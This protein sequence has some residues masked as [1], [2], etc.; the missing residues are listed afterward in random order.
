MG[1]AV[2]QGQGSYGIAP[3]SHAAPQYSA[4]PPVP[5]SQYS[6]PPPAKPFSAPP[7]Q[8]QGYS[9]CSISSPGGAAQYGAT[10]SPY[11][12]SYGTPSSN[13]VRPLLSTDLTLNVGAARAGVCF[14]RVQLDTSVEQRGSWLRGRNVLGELAQCSHTVAGALLIC[15]QE[16]LAGMQVNDVTGEGVPGAR[17]SALWNAPTQSCD[18]QSEK[19]E[20]RRG[21]GEC[22][23]ISHLKPAV[24]CRATRPCRSRSRPCPAAT[25]A[26]PPLPAS[27]RAA[28]PPTS[29]RPP[30][31]AAPTT[32]PTARL[33]AARHRH[34]ASLGTSLWKRYILTTSLT[35]V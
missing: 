26:V 2:L 32:A 33:A 21:G 13:S 19:M 22:V 24:M 35:I 15:S 5:V 18:G 6:A 11:A 25:P 31:A 10:S 12:G 34:P 16:H 27:T 8:A 29:R 9:N 23:S 30:R 3:P 14:T 17:E 7:P 28:T 4:S 20:K 1:L